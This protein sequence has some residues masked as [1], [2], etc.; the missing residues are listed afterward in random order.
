MVERDEVRKDFQ[1][2]ELAME[3]FLGCFCSSPGYESILFVRSGLPEEERKR[4][5]ALAMVFCRRPKSLKKQE[6]ELLQKVEKILGEEKHQ[7]IME[8]SGDMFIF[9]ITREIMESFPQ[10]Q[11]TVHLPNDL[12]VIEEIWNI[13]WK[14]DV[15]IWHNPNEDVQEL[16]DGGQICTFTA[17]GEKE[18]IA[19]LTE[20]LSP[21]LVEA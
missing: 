13:P 10:K 20:Y 19:K 3:S 4:L 11:F 9:P 16:P 21:Y 6:R 2:V 18:S 14:F 12:Q 17:L 15:L 1:V 7:E 5:L 8:Q